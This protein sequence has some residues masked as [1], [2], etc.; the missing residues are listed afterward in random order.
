MAN[1]T[2]AGHS[3][4]GMPEYTFL[5]QYLHK[6]AQETLY[7]QLFLYQF[8]QKVPLPGN[9]GRIINIP[10][11]KKVEP[12]QKFSTGTGT[13]SG[14]GVAPSA[15]FQMS[16]DKYTAE[17][18]GYHG[19][20]GFSDFFWAVHEIPGVLAAGVRQL[21][22]HL[23]KLYDIAIHDQISATGTGTLVDGKDG[24][25]GG[26][27]VSSADGLTVDG[28]FAAQT[29][30]EENL[31]P[32]YPDGTYACILHPRQVY[33]VFT[34]A[35]TSAGVSLTNWLNTDRGQKM[36]ENAVLGTLAKLKIH[37]STQ[38]VVTGY[39]TAFAMQS[40]S[41]GYHAPVIAPGAYAV[42]DLQNARPSIIIQP[43][44]SAG[45]ADPTK[46][47]MTVGIKG[48]FT[49]KAMDT[50]NRLVKISTGKIA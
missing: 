47:H 27:G 43:F 16:G 1:Y 5:G 14:E 15:E 37:V 48:Y 11:F 26:T 6:V 30:L 10:Y 46:T 18:F 25:A 3:A 34:N 41:S 39:G 7:P 22:A 13:A 45:T 23:A 35:E 49:A 9:S 31:A 28:L 32:T 8:G 42:I 21:S 12:V 40:A 38:S 20:I 33:D 4:P 17:M 2:I 44:G 50:S 36:Y 29:T 24:L 19:Y